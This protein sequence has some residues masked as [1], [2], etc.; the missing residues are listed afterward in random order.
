MANGRKKGAEAWRETAH[1]TNGYTIG[2]RRKKNIFLTRT[3]TVKRAM[4]PLLSPGPYLWLI[5]DRLYLCMT[6][7][8]DPVGYLYLLAYD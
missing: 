6:N 8:A 3:G 1:E 4:M 5:Y 2:Y 7:F